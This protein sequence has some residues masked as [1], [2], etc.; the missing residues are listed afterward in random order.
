MVRP[1]EI[2]NVTTVL[3][4]SGLTVPTAA[5]VSYPDYVDVRDG[6]DSFSSLIA[7]QFIVVSFARP[8]EPAFR[9][10]VWD[11]SQRK[12]VHSWAFNRRSAVSFGV[13]Q[14]R[15]VGRDAVVVLDH[16]LWERQFASDPGIV[17]RRIRISGADMIVTA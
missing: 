5:A 4:R 12:H 2:V 9:A 17:G 10:E 7:F 6:S 11:D 3:P 15:V 16:G 1:G 14:D 13:E 8:H